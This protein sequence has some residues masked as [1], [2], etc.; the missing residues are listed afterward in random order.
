MIDE[1]KLDF[2]EST[3]IEFQ[4]EN[5]DLRM[6]FEE[7]YYGKELKEKVTL[8]I[9]NIIS[10]DTDAV[11]LKNNLMAAEDGEVIFLNLSNGLVEVF[12]EWNNY[13]KNQHFSHGYKIAFDSYNIFFS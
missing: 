6:Q 11:N 4:K 5:N 7:V 3:I 1:S 12:I 10:I 2:H 9:N 8:I 13:A